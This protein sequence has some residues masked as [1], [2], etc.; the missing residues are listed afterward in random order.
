MRLAG[1]HFGLMAALQPLLEMPLLPRVP[2]FQRTR[3]YRN[4]SK[5]HPHQGE[6]EC[7]RRRRQM[8][9]ISARQA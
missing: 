7:A 2:L 9:K 1:I 8:A 5:Y 6:R 3:G 4:V